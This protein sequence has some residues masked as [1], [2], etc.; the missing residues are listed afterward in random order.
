MRYLIIA[1][2]L[3]IFIFSCNAQI[4]PENEVLISEGINFPITEPHFV[5][6]P[7]NEQHYLVAAIVAT[8]PEVL[9]SNFP[10]SHI[11]LF[12][13]YDAGLT[14]VAEH[15]DDN[16]SLGADPWLA[17]NDMG[18][19][20]LSALTKFKDKKP[21]Y[22]AT[23]TSTDEGK[24][25]EYSQNFGF[26]HDRQSMIL[27][28]KT[29]EFLIVSSKYLQD[30][31]NRRRSGLMAIQLSSKGTFMRSST[32]LHGN[33]DIQMNMPVMTTEGEL[34][35]PYIGYLSNNK[36]LKQKNTWLLPS[37]NFGKT[38]HDPLLMFNATTG[39]TNIV[40]DTTS[41]FKNRIYSLK[42]LG[43]F[44]EFKGFELLYSDNAGESWSDQKRIGQSTGKSDYMRNANM[45]V[46]KDGTL[47]I[48]WYDR[49]NHPDKNDI[50]FTA[51]TD[52]G[53]TFLPEIRITKVS[54]IPTTD[55]NGW[56]G[57]RWAVGGDY[58]GIQPLSNGSFQIVWADSRNGFYQLFTKNIKIEK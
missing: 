11:V 18:T 53:I 6:N 30:D 45:A 55:A 43:A 47:A 14:W 29:Q 51:S 26:G 41:N 5:I 57:K 21:V 33:V 19:V 20:I 4:R 38:F 37:D 12:Q 34:L 2:S 3:Q 27:N 36:M 1:L 46:N 10:A 22:L 8:E 52:G 15:F 24:T 49:R 40:I 7:N 16:V 50:Y 32:Y 31:R 39:H 25:W 28:P 42:A 17:L 58:S 56:T 9:D 13:S 35:I 48:F 23:Y 54:T 44:R